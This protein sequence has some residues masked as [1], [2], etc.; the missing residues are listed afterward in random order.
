[1]SL[2]HRYAW[3]HGEASWLEMRAFPV[4]DGLAVFWRDV[5]ERKL[6]EDAIRKSEARFRALAT[7]GGATIFRMSRDWRLMYELDSSNLR[8]LT[9]EPGEDWSRRYIVDEDR[10]TVFAAI[11]EAIRAKR[12][13]EL[14][15]RV[16]RADG[17]VGWV[18]SRAVPMLEADGEIREWFGAATDVTQRRAAIEQLR[19]SEERFRQ[20]GE[21]SADVL[22]IRDAETL[23]WEY[24]SPAFESIYGFDRAEA[25][26]G[27]GL[28]NWLSFIVEEDR[29]LAAASIRTVREGAPV[30]FEYRVRRPDGEVRWLRNTDFPMHRVGGGVARIGGI[31]RDVTGEKA[32]SANMEVLVGELHHRTRNLIAIVRSIANQTF[33]SAGPGERFQ[34]E[35][36][37]RLDA[38]ARVQRLLS[39]AADEPNTLEGL[40]RLELDAL[41][42]S[43]LAARMRIS[44][45]DLRL[46]PSVVQTLALAFHE[47]GTNARK[48]GALANPNGQLD[49]A[50]SI[51]ERAGKRNL[52]FVWSETGGSAPNEE[53]PE[54][55]GY[56]RQLLEG[57][58][59]YM[60]GGV[61]A[62]VHDAAGLRWTI[63][64]PVSRLTP[65]TS[66]D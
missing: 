2:E 36:G 58:L 28:R 49:I 39:R 15:H 44:G 42:A 27:R 32:T 10:R 66:T 50:W 40:L 48:H 35:F 21:A 26:A 7:T 23:D 57:A 8:A 56:G 31:G 22:W 53:T 64:L 43:A 6:S 45:P 54:R 18:H 33:A 65:L 17:S 61:A 11:D 16:R 30:T 13:F 1:V 29:D 14:E 37:D 52:D 38:L 24:L 62:F 5:T 46:R 55:G 60:L 9:V 34:I 51:S 25:L 4:P 3:P 47:L 59:P 19:E 12:M 41:G 20:F 63:T